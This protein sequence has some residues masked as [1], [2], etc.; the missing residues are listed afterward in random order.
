M[1]LLC[2]RIIENKFCPSCKQHKKNIFFYYKKRYDGLASECK[3]CAS[4]R[5]KK[6]YLNNK[7]KIDTKNKKNYDKNKEQYKIKSRIWRESNKEIIALQKEQYYIKNKSYINN[8]NKIYLRN[9]RRS[10][11]I[12]KLRCR[13][14]CAINISLRKE[15]VVKNNPTWFKL[16]YT[17]QQLKGHL[18]S[19]FD[20]NMTWE[21]YGIYWEIDHIYP[22]SLLPYDSLDH[23]NFL[24]CWSLNNLRPLEITQNRKKYNLIQTQ[25]SNI[26]CLN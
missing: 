23:P 3:A 24:K 13:I 15:M 14:S 5:G 26:Q 18:E 16:P 19:R 25:N 8:R 21:N 12:F 6:Y 20:S 7:I 1:I 17:P 4:L 11:L 9:R 10:D 2:M 22:Q